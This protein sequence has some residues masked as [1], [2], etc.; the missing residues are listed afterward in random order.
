MWLVALSTKKKL[1]ITW[2][3]I[4]D[5]QVIIDFVGIKIQVKA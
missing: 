3:K 4:L 1:A 2:A 5:L